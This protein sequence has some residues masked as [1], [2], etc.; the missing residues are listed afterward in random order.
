MYQ[1]KFLQWFLLPGVQ[2]W[3]SLVGSL[4]SLSLFFFFKFIYFFSQVSLSSPE[5]SSPDSGPADSLATSQAWVAVTLLL[6]LLIFLLL[7]R[8]PFLLCSAYP[9][10][11]HPSLQALSSPPSPGSCSRTPKVEKLSS[12]SLD[13]CS[14]Y[15]YNSFGMYHFQS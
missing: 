15:N 4:V 12:S 8:V 1:F 13:P 7:S 6:P 9:N 3:L 2:I 14:F 10:H 5:D 11:T